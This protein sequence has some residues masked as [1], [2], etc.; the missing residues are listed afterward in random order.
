MNELCSKGHWQFIHNLSREE[1]STQ[2]SFLSF[3]HSVVPPDDMVNK[4]EDTLTSVAQK[5]RLLCSQVAEGSGGQL[6]PPRS[7][8]LPGTVLLFYSRLQTACG[9]DDSVL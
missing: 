5:R 6:L 8:R 2:E 7:T 4:E 9:A 3:M 1:S